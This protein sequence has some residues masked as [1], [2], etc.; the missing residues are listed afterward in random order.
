MRLVAV[1]RPGY[2]RS[3]R[4][5]SPRSRRSPTTP[6][7]SPTPWAS[8]RSRRW[9]CPSVRR[10][11]WCAPRGIPIAC[12]PPG[13]SRAPTAPGTSPA[14]SRRSSSGS[15]P[16]SRAGSPASGRTTPTTTRSPSGSSRTCRPPTPHSWG[17]ADR[18]VAASLR[19]APADHDGYL[20]DA[21]LTFRPWDAG[22]PTSA[23]R[24][25]PGPTTGRGT[26][27]AARGLAGHPDRAPVSPRRRR[28][29]QTPHRGDARVRDPDDRRPGHGRGGRARPAARQHRVPHRVGAH[30]RHDHLRAALRARA[31]PGHRGGADRRGADRGRAARRGHRLVPRLPHRDRDP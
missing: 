14:P 4:H 3:D 16:S 12:E 7:R 2:G 21:A 13:W 8:T 30:R 1:N 5:A 29:T 20:R 9:A 27:G 17:D 11:R 22:P 26:L 28:A 10:T 25:T 24:S 19:E 31:R 15:V 18:Q 23:A 6:S